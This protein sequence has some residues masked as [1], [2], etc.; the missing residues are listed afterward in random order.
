MESVP[1]TVNDLVLG[2]AVIWGMLAAYVIYLFRER[3][4]LLRSLK[5]DASTAR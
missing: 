2:Y 5:K 3:S 1:N 4:Q